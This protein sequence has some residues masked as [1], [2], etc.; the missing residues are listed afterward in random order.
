MNLEGKKIEFCYLF[1]T[2]EKAERKRRVMEYHKINDIDFGFYESKDNT[3]FH[4]IHLDSGLSVVQLASKGYRQETGFKALAEKVREIPK[5]KFEKALPKT[6]KIVE[7]W[8]F[9]FPLND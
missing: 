4:A 6:K 5:A 7:A 9:S 3:C 8:G 1:G 2:E